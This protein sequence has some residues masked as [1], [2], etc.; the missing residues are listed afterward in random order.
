M[1]LAIRFDDV[2]QAAQR[3][4]GVAHRTPVLISPCADQITG[5]RVFFKCESFQRM[6]PFKFRGAYNALS[7][8]TPKQRQAG[9]AIG[10]LNTPRREPQAWSA[11]LPGSC[12]WPATGNGRQ[13]KAD[14]RNCPLHTGRSKKDLERQQSGVDFVYRSIRPRPSADGRDGQLSGV[15]PGMP[16]P[17]AMS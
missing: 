11:E 9:A 14:S 17:L 1:Q 5:A 7:Q 16:S 3:L 12:P 8:F 13:M 6:G 4:Q 15:P 2:A 10:V